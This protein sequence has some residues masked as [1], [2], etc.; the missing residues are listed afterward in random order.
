[1]A[2]HISQSGSPMERAAGYENISVLVDNHGH[3]ETHLCDGRRPP[4][5]GARR[6][7]S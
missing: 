3:T 1:M 7:R 2:R 4:R 6:T 5:Y